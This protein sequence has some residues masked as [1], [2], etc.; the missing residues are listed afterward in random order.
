MWVSLPE[1]AVS[2]SAPDTFRSSANKCA[3]EKRSAHG[4]SFFFHPPPPWLCSMKLKAVARN[5]S[6][7]QLPRFSC[8]WGTWS[9]G[10]LPSVTTPWPHLPFWDEAI[11]GTCLFHRNETPGAA[12]FPLGWLAWAQR[13]ALQQPPLP[14]PL[15]GPAFLDHGEPE[16]GPPRR[17][18]RPQGASP[19]IAPSVELGEGRC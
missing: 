17:S 1:G 16:G 5:G 19:G 13:G 9:V 15:W 12:L 18:H 10:L 4:T 2:C 14:R 6:W 7:W 11:C 3:P 8:R